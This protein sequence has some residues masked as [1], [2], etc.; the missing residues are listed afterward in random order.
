VHRYLTPLSILAL[1]AAVF[2]HGNQTAVAQ[3]AAA[4]SAT[5]Q[6]WE[7]TVDAVSGSKICVNETKSASYAKDSTCMVQEGWEPF[8][9]YSSSSVGVAMFRRCVK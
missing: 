3:E 1:A 6:Q 7:L 5:C 9:N 2:F 8:S 4:P